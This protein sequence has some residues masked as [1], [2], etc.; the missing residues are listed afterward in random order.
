MKYANALIATLVLG[1][2][3]AAAA[4]LHI[5]KFD[6]S[7]LGWAGAGTPVFQATGGAGDGGG[8]ILQSP[9]SNFAAYTSQADWIGSF[10]AIGADRVRVD[11]MAPVDSLAP[12]ELRLVL[13]T[14][15]TFEERW[16]ST[17]AQTVPNDGVWRS[18]TF[19]LDAA[20]LVQV[21]GASPYS[22][23]IGNVGRVMLRHDP[24]SP[25]AG[26]TSIDALLGIDN[27][28]LASGPA[29]IPG[30]FDGNGHVNGADLSNPTLGFFARF[31]GDL[32]GNSYLTWQ[33]NLGNPPTVG[34][35]AAA[36]EPSSLTLLLAA[37]AL[38][39]RR[40]TKSA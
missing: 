30:D 24:G 9:G 3:T 13:F 6:A 27:A 26:G 29:A 32:D 10:L 40:R 15:A 36:P 37:A 20:N 14:P 5:D 35:V 31:G 1:G 16:T 12:L 17:V 7:R 34:A 21:Q 28:E 11:L 23:L 38:G 18:Y 39:I 4:T 8:F 33:R 2:S 25:D 22:Q 19:M